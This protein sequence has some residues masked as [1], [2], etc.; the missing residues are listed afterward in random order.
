MQIQLMSM[1]KSRWRNNVIFKS[2]ENYTTPIISIVPDPNQPSPVETA[3]IKAHLSHPQGE[4]YAIPTDDVTN[5]SA[6]NVRTYSIGVSE[7]FERIGGD[8]KSREPSIS[9]DGDHVVF[10]SKASNLLDSNITRADGEIFYNS[11]IIA[12]RRRRRFWL[13]ELEKLKSSI[14]EPVMRTG[15]P[16][17]K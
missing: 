2:G 6:S 5:Q 4:V 10:S 17:H 8:N 1:G 11:P 9:H 7:N 13:V 16:F 12:A 15:F 14:Q 3:V